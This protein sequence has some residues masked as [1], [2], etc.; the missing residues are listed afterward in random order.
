MEEV[1]SK[2]N[3]NVVLVIIIVVLAIAVAGL[4]GY[5]YLNK[6]NLSTKYT[7]KTSEKKT[8]EKKSDEKKSDEEK[9]KN[10]TD[11]KSEQGTKTNGAIV[12][13]GSKSINSSIKDY[14]LYDGITASGVYAS[15]DSA[16]TTLTF[17]YRPNVVTEKYSLNWKSDI[18]YVK[19]DLIKLD[20]KI[21]DIHFS[22]MGQDAKGDTLF[23]LLEDGTVEYIP[24]VHMF[25]HAQ[26][27]AISYGKINGVSDVVKIV[28]A[29]M[30][31]GIT[32]LAIRSDGTFYD[33]WFALKDTGNY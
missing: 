13:N 5:I 7:T 33:L 2:K 1:K 8:D 31:G 9:T 12:F 4:G 25:N 24:I 23:I 32:T 28:S 27:K 29:N 21:A 10:D 16:Q 30:P 26:E 19:N 22:G 3:N 11:S 18:N 14:T 20:K 17:S 15:V 6:D